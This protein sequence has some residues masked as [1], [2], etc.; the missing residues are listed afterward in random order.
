MRIAFNASVIEP[1]SS[2]LGVYAVNLAKELIKLHDDLTL[3]TAF[4]EIC[5][6]DRT[7][8]R[9]IRWG[10]QPSLGI[11]GHIQR[12]LWVQAVL[13]LRLATDKVSLLLSP[14]PEG[15]LLPVV[16]QVVTLLDIIPL[17]FPEEYPQAQ[18]YARYLVP[19]I[20]RRS[21]GIITISENTKQDIIAHYGID[22]ERVHVVLPGCDR[23]RYKLGIDTEEVKVK[24]GPMDY[25][26]YV[27]NL[28]PHKNLKR[29][30]HAFALIADR[31]SFNLIIAGWKDRRYFQALEDEV[32]KLRLA[33][34]VSF[35][36]YIPPDELPALYAGAKVFVL[37]S[38]YEGFGLP[39]LE[40]MAC[41]CPVVVSNV[42]SQPEVCGDAAYYVNPQDV[43]SIAEGIYRVALDEELRKSLIHKGLQRVE[44]FS[45]EKTAA[46]HIKLL[47]KY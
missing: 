2:G 11:R 10:V 21:Q 14:L 7:K 13:P 30:L 34:R 39:P 29:L 45:W 3:Y 18:Y 23:S 43:K 42:A 8:V 24:Y 40:A 36:N 38:L 31:V 25:F 9:K 19:A 44:L 17:L 15:M 6:A 22:P 27:G 26:L 47:D 4:P 28:F 33:E 32:K 1:R 41:G 5:G 12:I 35:P 20:L 16:P 37:P 46:E